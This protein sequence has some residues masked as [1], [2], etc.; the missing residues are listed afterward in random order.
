MMPQNPKMTLDPAFE[1]NLVNL[2]QKMFASLKLKGQALRAG[3]KA[4]ADKAIEQTTKYALAARAELKA[5]AL[6]YA[7]DLKLKPTANDDT[8]VAQLLTAFARGCRLTRLWDDVM[9]EIPAGT[10]H[11]KKIYRII[12]P[13]LDAIDRRTDLALLLDDPDPSVRAR[14]ASLLKEAMPDRCIPILED[15]YRTQRMLDAGWI[16]GWALPEDS[17]ARIHAEHAKRAEQRR[18]VLQ[19]DSA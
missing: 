7:A 3:D 16:A 4:A 12:L 8:K 14:A 10:R 6:R 9:G 17:V 5:E 18:R 11:A 13:A 1:A 2:Q 19:A 15:V